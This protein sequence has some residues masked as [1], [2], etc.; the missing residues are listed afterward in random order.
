LI[1]R[2][3][4]NPEEFP[5]QLSD[6]S[7]GLIRNE[8]GSQVKM[9]FSCHAISSGYSSA[10]R[11]NVVTRSKGGAA[12]HSWLL[13]VP[14]VCGDTT[15]TPTPQ[16]QDLPDD[17]AVN[18]FANASIVEISEATERGSASTNLQRCGRS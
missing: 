3:K 10:T 9:S 13:E 16:T 1:W 14:I 11:L 15:Q 12:L 8:T 6:I 2:L 17:L 4:D 5:F 18:I 7:V